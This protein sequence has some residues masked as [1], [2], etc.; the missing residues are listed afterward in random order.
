MSLLSGF[1]SPSTAGP[2]GPDS[3]LR[4]FAE[5]LGPKG[6]PRRKRAIVALARKLSVLLLTL[7]RTGAQYEPLHGVAA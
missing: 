5:R 4:R 7:W 2:F 1:H 6:S 3:T